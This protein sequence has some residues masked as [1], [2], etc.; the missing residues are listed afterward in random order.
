VTGADGLTGLAL[1]RGRLSEGEVGER[2]NSFARAA[3]FMNSASGA[4][5]VGPT[6]VSF[7]DEPG[8]DIRIDVEVLR[9]K[10]LTPGP[11]SDAAIQ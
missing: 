9:G 10:A 2:A 3:R 4:G 11:R 6:K 5:G 7:P 8:S 1:L